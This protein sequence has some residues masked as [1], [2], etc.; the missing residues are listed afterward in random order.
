LED[1]DPRKTEF[2]ST[3]F[4]IE[5]SH[6][7]TTYY[8]AKL[9]ISDAV[10]DLA[11][12]DV[13]SKTEF[14][15]LTLDGGNYTGG[16]I[17]LLVTNGWAFLR[18]EYSPNIYAV[19][20]D[21][22]EEKPFTAFLQ[23]MWALAFA[24]AKAPQPSAADRMPPINPKY[25]MEKKAKVDED[26]RQKKEE[27]GRDYDPVI[28]E[29][30]E[31]YKDLFHADFTLTMLRTAV[32]MEKPPIP[33]AEF[34]MVNAW[35]ISIGREPLDRT[36]TADHIAAFAIAANLYYDPNPDACER[37]RRN[38]EAHTQE[39]CPFCWGIGLGKAADDFYG[40]IEFNFNSYYYDLPEAS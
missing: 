29:A 33:T 6:K 35:L 23:P 22:S 16:D 10:P 9:K 12:E 28:L 34:E 36:K 7:N 18:K 21:F 5:L 37:R 27:L 4:V 1:G 14:Q 17:Y 3:E 40:L 24:D 11:N 2:W 30:Y 26:F 15:F 32:F 20:T 38:G 8:L 39:Y 25:D 19:K 13:L 31:G